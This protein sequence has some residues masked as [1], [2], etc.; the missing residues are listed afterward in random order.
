VLR[1]V[2][3]PQRRQLA[4]ALIL[5][6]LPKPAERRLGLV[7]VPPRDLLASAVEEIVLGRTPSRPSKLALALF[8]LSKLAL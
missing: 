3:A 5:L 8:S 1:A 2:D 6:S 4:L 7:L